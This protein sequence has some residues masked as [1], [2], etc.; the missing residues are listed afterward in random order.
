MPSDYDND[1]LREAILNIKIKDFAAARRYLERALEL[2]DDLD[3]RCE[4]N[5]QMSQIT[6]DPVEKRNYLEETLAISPTHAEAR[7]ALAILDGKLKPQD[8]VDPDHL[9]A[10][11]SAEHSVSADRFT[12]PKCGARMVFDGDGRTLICENCA[13]QEALNPAAVQVEQ[14]F[15]IAMATGQ[16]QRKP[17]AMNAFVCQGCGA[18]ALLPPESISAT[19]SYC[20]SVY[21]LAGTTE[22][23]EPDSIIPMAF[24]QH[25]AALH[26]VQWVEKHKITPQGKV[27]APR[28]LY[29]PVWT[30]DITG[31]VP[32]RGVTYSSELDT[33]FGPSNPLSL[34]LGS[35]KYQNR[36]ARPVSGNRDVYFDDVIVPATSKLGDLFVKML[37][38]YTYTSVA[39]YDPRYLAGWPAEIY[40]TDMAEASLKARGQV[41]DQV[42]NN[43]KA[44]LSS[45]YSDISDV[46]YS[47]ASLAVVS[48]K[49]VLV[50]VWVTEYEL[51]SR[52]FRVLINGQN[53]AVHGETLSH[54]ILGWLDGVLGN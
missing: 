20:G 26:L 4:A 3:T 27:Q 46:G 29:L 12:C 16:S 37:K 43:I 34:S 25:D 53:G 11:S 33:S 15:I 17:V 22:L 54:G 1:L 21:V 28:G 51:E 45:E 13:R 48:F 40:E 30:F 36:Q 6:D 44:W 23:V 10:Q 50:P 35:G 9:P 7:R 47:T 5:F 32:W 24:N 52:Q 19:C 42:A 49:L 14:D 39:A 31:N 2:A 41:A 8:I 38:E 18:R